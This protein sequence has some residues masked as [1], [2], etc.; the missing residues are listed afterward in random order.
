M[1]KFYFIPSSRYPL[2]QILIVVGH[3][4][5]SAPGFIPNFIP[6]FIPGFIFGFISGF[7]IYLV[8]NFII[9]YFVSIY[10][11]YNYIFKVYKIYPLIIVKKFWNYN[12]YL[13]YQII[14]K[15]KIKFYALYVINF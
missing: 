4:P 3:C 6:G 11:Y 15:N 1:N 5:N 14:L 7:I 13:K 9:T 8:S 10:I 12:K 2:N